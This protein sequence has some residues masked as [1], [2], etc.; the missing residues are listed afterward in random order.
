[1]LR[2]RAGVW[3]CDER[4]IRAHAPAD[5]GRSSRYGATGPGGGA[6]ALGSLNSY[7]SNPRLGSSAA[8]RRDGEEQG[9]AGLL[10]TT[11]PDHGVTADTG[12]ASYRFFGW[13]CE[14]A[15]PAAI[16]AFLVDLGSRSTFEAAVA[17]LEPVFLHVGMAFTSF[18]GLLQLGV[19]RATTLIIAQ[20]P[21]ET[22]GRSYNRRHDAHAEAVASPRRPERVTA[23]PA[24]VYGRHVAPGEEVPQSPA[25]RSAIIS[26]ISSVGAA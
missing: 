5:F 6:G 8:R 2:H 24:S 18:L 3:S 1:V 26:R 15:L 4:S 12:G 11:G 9:R 16:L 23:R 19:H 13:R 25:P 7:A 20:D 10:P 22:S 14:R 21:S 17:A